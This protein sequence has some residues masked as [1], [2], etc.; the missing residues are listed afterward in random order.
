M[1]EKLDITLY[2]NSLQKAAEAGFP[3]AIELDEGRYM[4]LAS[5]ECDDYEVEE[6]V[7]VD[8]DG[9]MEISV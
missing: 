3:D 8:D 9:F 6:E 1:S 5:F 4:A 7:E 2:Y